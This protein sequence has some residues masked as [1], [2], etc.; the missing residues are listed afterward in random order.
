MATPRDSRVS[1]AL[2]WVV[3]DHDPGADGREA[4]WLIVDDRGGLV[5]AAIGDRGAV[6]VWSRTA[7]GEEPASSEPPTGPFDTIVLRLPRGHQAFRM[8]AHQLMARLAPEGTLLVGGANDEGIKPVQRR[9]GEVAREAAVLATRRHCRVVAARGASS[10]LRPELTAWSQQVDAT[11]GDV[12]LSW[13]SWPPLFAHG[14]LDPGTA[15]LLESLPELEGAVLDFACGAG[16]IAQF[17]QRR[18][19]PVQLTLSDVDALAVHAARVNVPGATVQV[20]DGV[21][22]DGGPWRAIVSNPPVHLGKQA[23]RGVLDALAATAPHRLS[24]NG[25][26]WIVVQGTVPVQRT[27]AQAFPS[28]ER[29][30][31]TSSYAVWRCSRKR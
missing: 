26:M 2:A 16:V 4:R 11:V 31:R 28:V 24:R 17:L 7:Y 3:E 14:R 12:A 27:L 25:A 5:R 20:A 1:E 15:L 29:V 21:P 10:E 22:V 9:L 13:S 30:A 8:V 19:D 23:D 6:E 18:G